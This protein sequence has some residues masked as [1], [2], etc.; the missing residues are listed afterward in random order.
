MIDPSAIPGRSPVE[1][2]LAEEADKK[3]VRYWPCMA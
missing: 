2:P 3:A 1:Q